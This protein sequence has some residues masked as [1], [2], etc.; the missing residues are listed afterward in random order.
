MKIDTQLS[1]DVI[2]SGEQSMTELV[3]LAGRIYD[4][5][6][7]VYKAT[8]SALGRV[9]YRNREKTIDELLENMCDTSSAHYKK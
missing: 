4:L 3:N 5:D 7:R 1:G 8:G 2:M 9:F 6:E